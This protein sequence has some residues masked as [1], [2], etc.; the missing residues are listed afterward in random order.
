MTEPPKHL[1]A[2]WTQVQSN[3][4]RNCSD[5]AKVRRGFP[6][7]VHAL[8]QL[9]GLADE[10]YSTASRQKITQVPFIADRIDEPTDNMCVPMLEA[11]PP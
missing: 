2:A 1:V 4:L 9:C 11:L 8:R 5:F 3:V 6:T 10:T 7:G